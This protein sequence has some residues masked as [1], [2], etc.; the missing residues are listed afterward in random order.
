E[1]VERIFDR[2]YRVDRARSRAMGGTGLGLAISK[3]M[4]NAHGG[5]IWAQSRY[6]K[7]TSIH[8]TLPYEIDDGGEW[9]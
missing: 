9:D 3:E 6:G 5:K 1:N 4:I 7:G 2:F 8:F